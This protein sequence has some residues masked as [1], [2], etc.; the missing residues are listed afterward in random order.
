MI[1]ILSKDDVSKV[2]D[3][4]LVAGVSKEFERLPDDYKYPDYGYFIVIEEL[5]ELTNPVELN[6]IIS[7]HTA[8]SLEDYLELIEEHECYCQVLLILHADFG[9]SLFV[10]DKLISIEQLEVLLRV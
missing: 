8:R 10:S 5:E 9:I 4:V 2:S 7:Q 1:Q 3:P 6:A